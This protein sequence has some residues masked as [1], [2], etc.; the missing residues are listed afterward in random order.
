VPK[1]RAGFDG[2]IMIKI[3]SLELETA[4][5]VDLDAQL[6]R[7][8]G[9]SAHEVREQL[10][11]AAIADHVGAAL[12]PFL[13]EPPGRIALAQA[14][15]VAGVAHVRVEVQ[16]LYDAELG[17]EA[18]PMPEHLVRAFAAEEARIA[19]ASRAEKEAADVAVAAPK[20]KSGKAKSHGGS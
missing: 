12:T 19:D 18:E 2:E 20:A 9:C 1:V 6:V 15:L 14:V 5:P 7:L 8:L 13:K 17:V 16:K 3:G 11:H 4:A 10:T